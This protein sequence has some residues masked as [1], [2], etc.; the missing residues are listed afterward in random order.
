MSTLISIHD[1]METM[2]SRDQ[3]HSRSQDAWVPLVGELYVSLIL[4]ERLR[5]RKFTRLA[6]IVSAVAAIGLVVV[7]ASIQDLLLLV[8]GVPIV[9]TVTLFVVIRWKEI[10]NTVGKRISEDLDSAGIPVYGA[11]Q[12]VS[13]YRMSQWMRN[14]QLSSEQLLQASLMSRDKSSVKP[15]RRDPAVLVLGRW[16][17]AVATIALLSGSVW[18]LEAARH[19]FEAHITASPVYALP[20]T[21]TIFGVTVAALIVSV[22]A[23]GDARRSIIARAILSSALVAVVIAILLALTLGHFGATWTYTGLAF[24]VVGITLYWLPTSNVVFH[25]TRAQSRESLRQANLRIAKKTS[26]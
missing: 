14:N 9:V 1:G 17:I 2:F 12:L 13:L 8:I 25:M 7:A 26:A 20:L 11:A 23:F 22:A 21:L 4:R 10:H 5:S 16:L 19:I 18:Q 3:V 24:Y 6:A 15:V